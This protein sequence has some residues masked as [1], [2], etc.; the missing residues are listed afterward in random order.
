M[1]RP[2][3]DL[4]EKLYGL[5]E[6]LLDQGLDIRIDDVAKAADVPRATLYYYFSGKE[7]L[8]SFLMAEK[9]DRMG[10]AVQKALAAGGSVTDRLE[11][12]VAA[13]IDAMAEAPS[14]CMNLL[15]AMGRGGSLAELILSAERAAFVPIRELLLE[16]RATG[17]LELDAA[18]AAI[19]G[20][21]LLATLRDYVS[22]G[23]IRADALKATLVPQLV[24]G[25]TSSP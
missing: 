4:A 18:C 8:V 15:A 24:R 20:A 21:V 10:A 6:E 25:L 7:D 12:V 2:P 22:N 3:E 19:G 13:M 23:E 14:L 16:G 9:A 5:S 1:K 11:G 17:D